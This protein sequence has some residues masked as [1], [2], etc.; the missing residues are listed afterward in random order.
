MTDWWDSANCIGVDPD[1]MFPDKGPGSANEARAV[2]A[3]CTVR[4]ACLDYA[5][6]HGERHG[7]WGGLT[8]KERRPLRRR[9]IAE[10]GHEITINGHTTQGHGT[11]A[12]YQR[13]CRRPEC[14]A[15]NAAYGRRRA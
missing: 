14:R 2:C 5:L 8:P 15:A 13:G 12:C 3:G 1:I 6:T 7:V 4:E 10:R 11:R 9:Y